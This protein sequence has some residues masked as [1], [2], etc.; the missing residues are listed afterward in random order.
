MEAGRRV[1]VVG[2]D[3]SGQ[4][5]HRAGEARHVTEVLA[6]RQTLTKQSASLGGVALGQRQVA[7]VGQHARDAA[8][9]ADLLEDR[10]RF[11][12]ERTGPLP[13]ARPARSLRVFADP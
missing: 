12:V 2:R 13:I 1:G 5:L 4:V 8:P 10:Q 7:Q 9:V 3:R 11:S 6:D